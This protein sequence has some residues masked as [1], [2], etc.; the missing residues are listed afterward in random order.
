MS[1]EEL[2]DWFWN[3]FNCCYPVKSDEFPDSIFWFY[4][5]TFVRKQ[6]ICK[7]NNQDITFPDKVKGV[8]LFDQDTRYEVFMCDY[9][10]IWTYFKDNYGDDYDYIQSLISDILKEN[11]NLNEY[12][13]RYLKIKNYHNLT[14]YTPVIQYKENIK[15]MHYNIKLK[16]Y[17]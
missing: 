10:L 3:K 6:K 8:C 9:D 17:E 4:D 13:P 7:L 15:N 16:I 12:T 11:D 5:E 14:V 2:S 1:K